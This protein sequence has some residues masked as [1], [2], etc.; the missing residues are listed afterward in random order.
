MN[1]SP[2]KYLDYDVSL[3]LGE[4]VRKEILKEAKIFHINHMKYINNVMVNKL[5]IKR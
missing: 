5:K 3:L 2:L 4:L 1:Q